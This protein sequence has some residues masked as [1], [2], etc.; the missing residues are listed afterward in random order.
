VII[1]QAALEAQA[2]HAKGPVLIVLIG[3]EK[4]KARFRDAPRRM[5]CPT[6]GDLVAHGA[7][8]ARGQERIR[9]RTQVQGRHEIL[10][11][12]AAP[13]KQRELALHLR[14]RPAQLQPVCRGHLA[15]GN[16]QDGSG[17]C[18]R[19]EQIIV[20][21]VQLARIE[22]IA[23]VKDATALVI[24]EGHVH[25]VSEGLC[26]L[27][28]TLELLG[29]ARCLL[30]GMAQVLRHALQPRQSLSSGQRLCLAWPGPQHGL[31]RLAHGSG[32]RLAL[33]DDA[34]DFSEPRV[35]LEYSL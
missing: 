18:L 20:A 13:G 33:F 27:G 30:I 21:I 8:S 14:H 24:Q 1:L 9:A 25:L 32:L 35:G 2:W 5:M 22:V 11:H 28:N 34:A 12:G 15:P 7:F 3:I 29:K 4:V 16:R 19:G 26:L 6:I 10:E 31:Y 23:N 17:A